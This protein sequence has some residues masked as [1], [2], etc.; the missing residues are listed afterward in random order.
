MTGPELARAWFDAWDRT[1]WDAL[2][3]V[4]DRNL[5]MVA[6]D[7]WPEGGTFFGWEQAR[8]Q[9]ERLKEPWEEERGEGYEILEAGDKV[10]VRFRWVGIGKESDMRVETPMS[11]LMTPR[12]GKMSHL[13]FFLGSD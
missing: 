3:K 2:E 10:L 9:W 1:D 12:D 11:C 7:E 6:P 13:E 4:T 5:V 8:E